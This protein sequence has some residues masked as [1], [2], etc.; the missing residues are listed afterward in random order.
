[1]TDKVG[2]QKIKTYCA[3]CIARCGAIATVDEG[4][5]VSL[6]PDPTHPTGQA[7]CAK[8]RAA[9]ELVYSPERLHY[10]MKRTRPKGDPNPGWERIGWDEALDMTAAAMRRIADQHG[11]EA[12]AFSQASG[13]TTAI[14]DSAP[15]IGR[16]MK[17]FGTPNA[18]SPLELCGWGRAYA[19]RYTYGV[20]SV[21]VGAGGGAMP[22]IDNAG[23]VILWGYNPSMSRLTHGTAVVKGLKRGMRLIVVDPRHVGLAS[24]ADVWLRVRPGTDGALALGLANLMIE[25]G[26]YDSQ[27]LRDW[28]NG[29]MLVRDDTGRLLT[30][31]DLRPDG[32]DRRYC[33]WDTGTDSL[34]IYD[35]TA[36]AY[37][38]TDA[39]PALEGTYTVETTEG[40]VTCRPTFA[41][42]AALCRR[43]P[44]ETVASTCWIEPEQL[45]QA[46]DLIWNARPTAYYAWSGHEQHTNTTQTARAIS[47]LYALTGS[48]DKVGG[49]VLFPTVPNAPVNGEDIPAA[50]NPAPALGVT[51][52][53][54]GP[55]RWN[56][57]STRDVY[58]AILEDK[59]YPVR[60]LLGFGAN[61]LVAHAGPQRGREALNALDF[62]AHF[63][64]FMTP[65]AACADVILPVASPFERDALKL[66]FEISFEAQSWLQYRTPLVDPVG[67]CKSDAEIVFALAQRLGLGEHFWDGD[68]DAAYRH[69]LAPSGVT[70]EELRATPG[71]IRV[72][73]QTTYE[74]HAEAGPDGTPQG[75]AT[76]SRKIE[77]WSETFLEHGYPALPEFEELI[78]GPVSRPDLA[79]QFP[80]V[81]T[82]AK[83]AL[84]CNSQHRALPSLRKRHP[85]PAV[86]LHPDSAAARGIASGDW[87]EVV[88]P[89]GSMRA[90]ANLN[91]KIDPRIVVGQHGWWQACETLG[92][93]SYD[94][95]DAAG[96]N[97]NMLIGTTALDPISGTASH[98]AYLCDVRALS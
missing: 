37:K 1:M 17:A 43:Y 92:A 41:L 40:A 71:G 55:A 12:V 25:R 66:G 97:F 76:P 52:R 67:E 35:S 94:P 2:Q 61:I 85:D 73:L 75:F 11:P 74:K 98:K 38:R 96:S 87:V 47:L 31:R 90:R 21:G 84:F 95:F 30:E 44:P 33:A 59:P 26:W 19:T 13:S 18:A 6:E 78:V 58:R 64:M 79:E 48:F 10:P 4:R 24:K 72:P 28:S 53:P 22:D 51:E 36:G 20:G 5:L 89:D 65:T 77:I 27:F 29:P 70:L 39:D 83:N 46:A 3:L 82:S 80:L 14:G 69:Q 86:E 88:S 57:V 81:L 15:W 56:N 54:L 50:Q 60:G 68:L 91:T 49:N 42:Y 93:P 34:V 45:E 63:D 32:S 9:P 62:Y 8:G 16:L 23:C 7:L